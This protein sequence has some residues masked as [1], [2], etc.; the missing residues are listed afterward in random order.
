M[1]FRTNNLSTPC[2]L[3]IFNRPDTTKYVF[4][5][6]RK[7]RPIKL[8]VAADGPRLNIKKDQHQCKLAKKV[9]ENIDW[10]C[11]LF[12]RFRES[13]LGCKNSVTDSINWFFSH[14]D[15]GIILEDDCVP[16]QSF[17]LF[18]EQLLC[19]FHDDHRIGMISGNNHYKITDEESYHF[20]K[21]GLIWGWATWKRAW[22]KNDLYMNL[23]KTV[24]IDNLFSNIFQSKKA[25]KY[26]KVILNS[27]F[28]NEI[29][30]WDYQWAFARYINN[31]LTIRPNKNLVANIGF[32]KKAAHTKG[33]PSKNILKKYE[34]NF[35]LIHPQHVKAN[36]RFDL[37]LEKSWILNDR[38]FIRLIKKFLPQNLWLGLRL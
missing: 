29:D 2:L 5:E 33:K 18:C 17:F 31:L 11:E 23:Y 8:F 3:I 20:S 36:D 4:D 12:T 37:L 6:I 10:N 1:N 9:I 24:D 21:H 27:A 16:S 30:T 7:V 25:I 22:I 19:R 26:W 14:V 28:S 15:S 13:N 34:L 32:G 35:P 38:R